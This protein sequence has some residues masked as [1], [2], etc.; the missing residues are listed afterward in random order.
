MEHTYKVKYISQ[1]DKNR[2]KKM[3]NEIVSIERRI[4]REK[5]YIEYLKELI[6][7]MEILGYGLNRESQIQD[8][9]LSCRTR[10]LLHS[11]LEDGIFSKIS[12]LEK[13]SL[14][15]FKKVKGVGKTTI[16]ELCQLCDSLNINLKN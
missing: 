1:R 3:R 16:Y 8:C 6:K 10:N 9:H 15:E 13:I 7:K 12:S 11:Y 14:S 5:E 4:Q 2:L